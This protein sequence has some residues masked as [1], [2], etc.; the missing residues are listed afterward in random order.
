MKSQQATWQLPTQELP[1]SSKQQPS[2]LR[3]VSPA[4]I[5]AGFAAI[6]LA[7]LGFSLILGY[8]AA[9]ASNMR[10]GYEELGLRQ[11]I[12]D[13]RAQTALLRYHIHLTESNERIPQTATRLGLKAGDPIEE[14]DY[15]LLP[16][17]ATPDA[18]QLAE[19]DPT[20]TGGLAAALA[21]VA[22]GVVGSAEGRAE[23]STIDSRRR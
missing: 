1:I 22:A 13:L 6:A 12:E 5:E 3:R 11:Q 4:G 9:T 23:A 21:G 10:A 2:S 16:H 14:V 18:R 19:S 20:E 7:A 8:A 17:S 15:V